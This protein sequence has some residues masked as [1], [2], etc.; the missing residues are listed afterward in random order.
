MKDEIT[1]G[2]RTENVFSP[3]PIQ[4]YSSNWYFSRT[5]P[6]YTSLLQTGS[7][8]PNNS[9]F[10]TIFTFI[11]IQTLNFQLVSTLKAV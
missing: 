7:L 1:P 3:M 9:K 11:V 4:L 2:F 5:S 8:G 10:Y 6:T